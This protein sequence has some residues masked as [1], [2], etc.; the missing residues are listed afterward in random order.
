MAHGPKTID[1]DLPLPSVVV[2]FGF[3]TACNLG[4]DLVGNLLQDA[5]TSERWFVVA[6]AR[7][8][9]IA[10]AGVPLSALPADVRRKALEELK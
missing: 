4:K 3:A 10:A 2:T 5:A 7:A 6:Y 8:L 1:N 9:G